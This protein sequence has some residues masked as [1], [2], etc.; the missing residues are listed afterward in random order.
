MLKNS[1]SDK[2]EI[3]IAELYPNFSS[4]EQTEAEFNLLGYLDVVRRIFERVASE[5]PKLL[6]E[7]EKTASL[8]QKRK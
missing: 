8:K 3:T 5:N 2:S 6:T 7:L 1:L 4:A